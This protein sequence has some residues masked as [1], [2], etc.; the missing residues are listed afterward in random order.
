[1]DANTIKDELKKVGISI[2]DIYDLVN[3]KESYPLAIPV[4][5]D[6]LQKGIEDVKIKEGIIRA[7]AVKEAIGKASPILIEEYH[8]IAKDKMMLRW[9]IGNTIYVTITENDVDSI[10]QIVQDDENGM[11]RQMFVLAL[12]KVKSEK[13]EDILIKLLDDEELTPHALEA[14]GRLKSK[15][16]KSKIEILTKHPKSLIKK[17]AE[18][19]LKKIG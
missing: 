5:L 12:G 1:M 11:S 10:L 6:L 17:E 14:L 4:L 8:K 2:N 15:K 16:A 9:A 3:T 18:K 7:L 13:A 19:A